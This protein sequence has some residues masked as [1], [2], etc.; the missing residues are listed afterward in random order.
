MK[1]KKKAWKRLCSGL[2]I[3]AMVLSCFPVSALAAEPTIADRIPILCT[4]Q[5]MDGSGSLTK[6]QLGGQNKLTPPSTNGTAYWNSSSKTIDLWVTSTDMT[7][8]EQA[9]C[10]IPYVTDKAEKKWYLYQ[11]DWCTSQKTTDADAISGPILDSADIKKAAEGKNKAMYQFSPAD[12]K[13]R[14]GYDEYADEELQ[15]S[16]FIVYTW[17]RTEPENW[18]D[19]EG[20]REEYQVKYNLDLPETGVTIYPVILD[21]NEPAMV[22]G[23]NGLTPED[24]NKAISKLGETVTE[25][26]YYNIAEN[27]DYVDFLV[28]K[29]NNYY[30]FDGWELEKTGEIY[31]SREQIKVVKEMADEDKS[32]TITGKWKQIEPYTKTQDAPQL[33]LLLAEDNN[34]AKIE[35]WTSTVDAHTTENVTLDENDTIYYEA[36]VKMNDAVA[37]QLESKIMWDEN[38]AQF[39]ITVN[40]DSNLVLADQA[41]DENGKVSFT[42]ICPFLKPTGTIVVDGQEVEAPYTTDEFDHKITVAATAI[43]NEDGTIK[44]FTIPVKWITGGNHSYQT[45]KEDIKLSNIALK[46]KTDAEGK[47]ADKNFTIKTTGDVSGMINFACTN[48]RVKFQAASNMLNESK[49]W[50][51]YFGGNGSDPTAVVH[52]TQY[53]VAQLSEKENS[54][55]YGNTV[56]ATYPQYAI[57]ASADSNGSINPA[58]DVSVWKHGDQTFTIN[59]N[60]GY[61]VASVKV[62]GEDVTLDANGQYT[63]T[64]VT[65]SHLIFASFAKDAATYTITVDAGANGTITLDDG[66]AITDGQVTVQE[67]LDQTFTIKANEGYH[68]ASVKVDGKDVTLDANGQYTFEDVQANHTISATFAKNTVTYTI[69]VDAGANGTIT[70]GDGSAITDGQVTVNEGEDQTF[71]IKPNSGYRIKSV[72]VDG[73]TVKLTEKDQYI[74]ANIQNNHTISA[75]FERIPS[76]SGSS[77]G[78]SSGGSYVPADLNSADHVAYVGGYPDGTVRPD[79][80]VTRAETAAMLYRLLTAERQTAIHT[81]LHSF[82]DIPAD[83]WYRQPVASMAKG[84]YISGYPDGTFGGDRSITRAEFVTMLVRFIGQKEATCSFTDVPQSHW[85]YGTIATATKAGWVSGYTDGTFKPDQSITRAE[86]MTI[87]NRVLNRGVNSNSKLLNFKIWPDNDSAAWYYYEV[88]EATNEHVYTGSRPSENWTSLSI[89]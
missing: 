68:V 44:S 31:D 89:D 12:I 81:T 15:Y 16:Y 67:G 21:K 51:D 83:A 76:S 58:G 74:F 82:S 86:A 57:T 80:P 65:G 42:F 72:T 26:S 36:T 63:F 60:K 7:A 27:M 28:F 24:F 5:K 4:H 55:L 49:E 39:D 30:A 54:H 23:D 84:S 73:E 48:P 11:I 79:N 69:T 62:D 56:T 22:I 75:T 77:S 64:N 33:D 70:L 37:R 46:L 25:K 59:A 61:H 14:P 71:T 35:Q 53:I 78:G 41:K 47:V 32:I 34:G 88:I 13:A 52:A 1:T 40:I 66:S 2:L 17:T 85:A 3:V 8:E 18:G 10:A 45:L 43:T 50:E 87:I 19:L 29:D 9:D 6:S 20:D 38:F